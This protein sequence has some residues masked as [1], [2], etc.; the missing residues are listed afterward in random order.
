MGRDKSDKVHPDSLWRRIRELEA[1]IRSMQDERVE[2]LGRAESALEAI[3]HAHP[4]QAGYWRFSQAPDGLWWTRIKW[5]AG[6]YTGGYQMASALVLADSFLETA[7]KIDQVEAGK[8][9][10]ILDKG[11]KKK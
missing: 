10:P 2:T 3:E 11:Y 5:T 6:P 4:K 8:L 9:K 1:I 7:H